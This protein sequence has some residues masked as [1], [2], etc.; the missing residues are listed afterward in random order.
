M[1]LALSVSWNALRHPSVED[2]L[3]EI[4]GLGFKDIELS[5]NLTEEL[6]RDIESHMREMQIRV[7]SLHNYCPIPE[8]FKREEALPDCCSLSSL[9]EGERERAL[10]YTKRTIDTANRLKARAVVLHCGK[11]EIPDGTKELIE[12][13]RRGFKDTPS[14][15][16]LKTSMVAQR[17]GSIKPFLDQTVRSLEELNKH[18]KARGVFLGIETRFYYREIPLLDEIGFLLDRFKDSYIYYW[19]DTGH[20]EVMQRLGFFRHQDYLDLYGDRMIGIHLHDI[21]KCQDHMAPSQGDFDFTWLRPYVKKETIKVIEAHH[22]ATAADI[23]K[24]KEY[25]EKLFYGS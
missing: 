7:V 3:F 19:H 2:A 14:F 13:Y 6:L 20:A 9:D 25:L 23:K 21:L 5:F 12:L 15:R 18:A 4:K 16:D 17:Q 10:Y 1:N 11:V 8:G 24:G 22:P